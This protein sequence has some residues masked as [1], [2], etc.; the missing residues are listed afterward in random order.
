MRK[1]NKIMMATVSILL[2][3]VLISSCV[4]SGIFAKYVT[5]KT[6]SS[7]MQFEK[8]GVTVNM[9][10]DEAKLRSVLGD[11][12]AADLK[13][14][15]ADE[16]A[17]GKIWLEVSTSAQKQAGVNTVT[18]HNLALKPGDDL[19]NLIQFTISGNAN[20]RCRVNMDID[21]TYDIEDF[22]VPN[23]I[24]GSVAGGSPY[25]DMYIP[26]NLWL[27][28]D[29]YNSGAQQQLFYNQPMDSYYPKSEHVEARIYYLSGS[30]A[31]NYYY[32]YP[33]QLTGTYD[34]GD[35]GSVPTDMSVEK[36]FTPDVGNGEVYF[37]YYGV[38]VKNFNWG[39]SWLFVD[40]PAVNAVETYLTREGNNPSMTL[41][42]T[43][44]V[45]QVDS[46]Y[47]TPELDYGY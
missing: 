43:I 36:I 14:P 37:D 16:K 38:K 1:I 45:E 22:K 27:S 5:T 33:E 44:T 8:F 47:T 31:D 3:L 46:E 42:Y 9:V 40:D 10:V 26:I 41:A 35:Y 19:K 6:A 21:V 15:T 4:L 11:D 17:A 30:Y 20:V 29:E 34:Y 7:Q 24:L 18:I 2:T 28:M 32:Y 23:D 39:V 25:Y 12:C 13:K